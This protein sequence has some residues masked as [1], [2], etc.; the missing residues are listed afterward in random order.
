VQIH[1]SKTDAICDYCRGEDVYV[2][3]GNYVYTF[4]ILTFHGKVSNKI[5]F[6]LLCIKEKLIEKHNRVYHSR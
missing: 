2:T 3:I 1:S 6:G 5:S 4:R